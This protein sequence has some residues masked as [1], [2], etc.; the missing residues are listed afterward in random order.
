MP[1]CESVFSHYPLSADFENEPEWDLLYTE[2]TGTI[3]I[4]L[5]GHE[6]Q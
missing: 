5:E 2:L 1:E 3:V 6:L 4:Y